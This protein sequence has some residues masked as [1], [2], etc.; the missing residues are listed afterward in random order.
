MPR[1]PA[2][3][4]EGMTLVELMVATAISLIVLIAGWTLLNSSTT[5][6]NMIQNGSQ[7]SEEARAGIRALQGD[8]WH[9][10][11]LQEGG[12]ALLFVSASSVQM[13][14]TD[15]LDP[16]GTIELLTWAVDGTDPGNLKLVR[17]VQRP[18][19]GVTPVSA[20]GFVGGAVTSSVKVTGLTSTYLFSSDAPGLLSIRIH[21]AMGTD[22]PGASDLRAT[23]R[24]ASFVVYGS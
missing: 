14:V 3:R 24:V 7:A 10:R 4:Q 19:A 1:D 2:A 12:D 16:S 9:A 20:A 8:V 15:P 22:G 21:N 5:M 11:P 17:T 6:L 18:P 13:T 23:F